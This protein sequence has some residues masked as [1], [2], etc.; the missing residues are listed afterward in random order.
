ML[1]TANGWGRF[2]LAVLATWR[3]THLLASEDGP[4]DLIV[5]FRALLGDGVAGKLMDCFY[6]LSLWI[7]APAALF[8]TR[9][10]LEWVFVWLAVSG[11]ASLLE[12]ATTKQVGIQNEPPWA[13]GDINNVLRIETS[14]TSGRS[15][16][17]EDNE[18]VQRR[19]H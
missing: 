6:C 18:F 11:G 5:R 15:G 9:A 19:V 14:P 7:A 10:A 13:E 16:T 8:V 3:V 4:A 2:V 1:F 17:E 12:R